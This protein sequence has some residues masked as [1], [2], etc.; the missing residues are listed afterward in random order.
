M[1]IQLKDLEALKNVI[2]LNPALQEKLQSA[3]DATH[4][5]TLLREIAATSPLS[6]VMSEQIASLRLWAQDRTIPA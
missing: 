2:E 4:R 3:P 1:V 5:T 6:V